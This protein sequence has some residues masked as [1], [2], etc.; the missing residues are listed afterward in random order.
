MSTLY[1]SLALHEIHSIGKDLEKTGKHLEREI[2]RNDKLSG[3]DHDM[4]KLTMGPTNIAL[5]KSSGM[6]IFGCYV[7]PYGSTRSP[8]QC[9]HH[10][11]NVVLRI[12]LCRGWRFYA[13][14]IASFERRIANIRRRLK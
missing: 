2:C 1:L 12:Q 10:I 4:S 7:S 11:V 6:S 8:K 3:K 14:D 9:V 13:T 5:L